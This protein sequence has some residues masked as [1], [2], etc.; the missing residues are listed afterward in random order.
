MY[1]NLVVVAAK[2]N[3]FIS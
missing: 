2:E 1:F 3:M